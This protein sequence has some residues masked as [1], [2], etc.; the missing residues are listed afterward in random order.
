MKKERFSR[1]CNVCSGRDTKRRPDFILRDYNSKE[2]DYN[3]KERQGILRSTSSKKKIRDN[4]NNFDNNILNISERY[5]TFRVDAS[6]N[7]KYNMTEYKSL[8]NN[9]PIPF[10]REPKILSKE[11][12]EAHNK[13]QQ[14]S[15]IFATPKSGILN[16]Q[17]K[18][19]NEHFRANSIQ[20]KKTIDSRY[21]FVSPSSSSKNML[22]L[23]DFGYQP[24]T[25]NKEISRNNTI[26]PQVQGK[27]TYNERFHKTSIYEIDEKVKRI[28]DLKS[29]LNNKSSLNHKYSNSILNENFGID[30]SKNNSVKKERDREILRSRI[31][32]NFYNNNDLKGK[33]IFNYNTSLN[34]QERTVDKK[35]IMDHFEKLKMQ[36]IENQKNQQIKFEK[37]K[38]LNKQIIQKE[39]EKAKLQNEL[40]LDHERSIKNILQTNY[41]LD[42]DMKELNKVF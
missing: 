10:W 11:N 2:K 5:R 8:I 3:S 42:M 32:S 25:L 12:L 41:K 26:Y 30:Y 38:A 27:T 22:Q 31:S 13:T 37:E 6:Q 7:K 28:N 9:I 16:I 18:T 1:F 39:M 15:I 23:N 40:R 17:K 29:E 24:F 34:I 19:S 36:I 21:N 33:E 20:N 4:I 14:N 35:K